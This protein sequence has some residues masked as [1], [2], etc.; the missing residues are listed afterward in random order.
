MLNQQFSSGN[1]V[2]ATAYG[3]LQIYNRSNT[4]TVTAHVTSPRVSC[5]QINERQVH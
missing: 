3:G 5:S 2:T 1:T 4:H